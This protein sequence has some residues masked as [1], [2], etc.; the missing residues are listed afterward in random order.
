MKLTIFFPIWI[1]RFLVTLF[2]TPSVGAG[3]G[4]NVSRRWVPFECAILLAVSVIHFCPKEFHIR[5]FA[6]LCSL[7]LWPSDPYY[8]VCVSTSL[9]CVCVCVRL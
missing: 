6:N 4:D 3:N 2:M 1:S 7:L 9:I 8:H 5:L